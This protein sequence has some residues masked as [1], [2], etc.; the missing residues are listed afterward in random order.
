[1]VLETEWDDSGRKGRDRQK[2]KI[3]K[4]NEKRGKCKKE[5]KMKK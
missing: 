5:Q 1:M 2:Q 3:G 4:V